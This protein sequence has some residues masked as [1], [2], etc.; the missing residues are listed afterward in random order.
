MINLHSGP[1]LIG[2]GVRNVGGSP[3]RRADTPR[4]AP[5]RSSDRAMDAL[6]EIGDD[7][8]V[9]QSWIVGRGRHRRMAGPPAVVVPGVRF[10]FYGRTST[11]AWS[12]LAS[13]HR[14]SPREVERRAQRSP[15]QPWVPPSPGRCRDGVGHPPPPSAVVDVQLAAGVAVDMSALTPALK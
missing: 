9:L 15:H 3:G 4:A 7:R 13:L 2:S 5:W 10:A 8:N 12:Y 14:L 11:A 6:F 1:D